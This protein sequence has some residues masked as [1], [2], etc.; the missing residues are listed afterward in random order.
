[1][2]PKDVSCNVLIPV[3]KFTP[4]CAFLGSLKLSLKFTSPAGE[5]ARLVQNITYAAPELV[6]AVERSKNVLEV[7]AAADMWALGVVALEVATGAPFMSACMR[8]RQQHCFI[9]GAVEQQPL[10]SFE[11][12]H[13]IRF[14]AVAGLQYDRVS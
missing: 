10:I 5:P 7:D 2:G 6:T 3:Y 4:T 12:Q 9:F 11:P 13:T 8:F 14:Q 1:M